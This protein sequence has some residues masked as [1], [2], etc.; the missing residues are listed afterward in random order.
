M[1]ARKMLFAAVVTFL[2]RI[3]AFLFGRFLGS[4][5]RAIMPPGIHLVLFGGLLLLVILLFHRYSFHLNE[6][7]G[8]RLVFF[9]LISIL[10]FI[11]F[12]SFS[13]R[14]YFLFQVGL[15][16]SE[17]V[18][19]VVIFG[20]GTVMTAETQY[21]TVMMASSGDS[22]SSNS[23]SWTGKTSFEERV[24]QEPW[25]VTHN[26]GFESSMHNRISFLE[27][28]N[29]LFLLDKEKGVYWSDI[30][31]ELENCSSQGEYNRLLDFENRDLQI[32]EQKHESYSIFRNILA[33]HPALEKNAAYN[34]EEAFVDFLTAKRDELDH[35][36]GDVVVRDQRELHFLNGVSQDLR[37]H[38]PNSPYL[39]EILAI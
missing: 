15:Y 16:F 37:M 3:S 9:I 26:S 22:G 36:G 8:F 2:N 30:K 25:P 10:F 34:P 6:K 11:S 14:L 12:F 17:L 39:R 20:V 7:Y 21:S 1:Q 38:G 4:E 27:S 33:Q 29:S 31:G 35:Q 18:S 23:S 19:F 32:R 28:K 5:G 24:L 13:L